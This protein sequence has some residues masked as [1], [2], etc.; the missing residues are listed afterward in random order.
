MKFFKKKA[1]NIKV[2]QNLSKEEVAAIKIEEGKYPK[3]NRLA[4]GTV[5]S[6][7]GAIAYAIGLVL[8]K[9]PIN[10]APYDYVMK[11][12]E[13]TFII[14]AQSFGT[15]WSWLAGLELASSNNIN[16]AISILGLLI[17]WAVVLR[18]YIL[19]A[20]GAGILVARINNYDR[21]DMSGALKFYLIPGLLCFLYFLVV[22]LIAI[23]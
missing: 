15:V 20:E 12:Y 8:K 22:S 14:T 10:D 2:K 13:L 5:L 18:V 21:P 11:F 3:S 4:V 23:W 9:S 19:L 7:M 17:Y 6:I 16:K 1:E